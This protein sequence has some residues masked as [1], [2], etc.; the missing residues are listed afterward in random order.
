VSEVD[1]APKQ[2]Q[3]GELPRY[4][5]QGSR[6]HRDYG[7]PKPG[8][9]GLAIAALAAGICGGVPLAV[10]FGIV[11]LSQI[12]DTRQKG[13]GFAV[14]GLAAAGAWTLVFVLAIVSSVHGQA[15]RSAD[16]TV[17]K[18]G[19]ST[20]EELRVGDC[21]LDP[22][23]GLLSEVTVVPCEQ[24]HT[25]QVVAKPLSAVKGDYPGDSAAASESGDLCV[26][27]LKAVVDQ[28]RVTATMS[29]VSAHPNATAWDEGVRDTTCLLTDSK[30]FTGSVLISQP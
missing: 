3:P 18:K 7:S 21:A 30:P 17:T 9:N 10:I 24:P 22:G 11:A 2:P 16:G 29:L 4:P 23:T 14:A 28:T 20:V 6:D 5:G 19:T 8:T 1:A 25:A 26:A 27:A 15:H 12:G 13:K